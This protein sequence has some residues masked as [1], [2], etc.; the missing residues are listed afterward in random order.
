[1]AY[2]NAAEL[3]RRI[4]AGERDF[5]GAVAAGADLHGESPIGADPGGTDLHGAGLRDTE[6][7]GANLG[8][9]GPNED[10]LCGAFLLDDLTEADLAW[11]SMPDGTGH[12]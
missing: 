1:M 9:A 2:M 3:R 5:P 12:E 8:E 4:E 7:R 6:L 11:L 10:D